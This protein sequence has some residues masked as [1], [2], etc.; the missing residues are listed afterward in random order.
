MVLDFTAKNLAFTLLVDL[1]SP[2]NKP[3]KRSRK[4]GEYRPGDL[5]FLHVELDDLRTIKASADEFKAQEMKLHV[6][7]YRALP[8][9]DSQSSE[10]Q[11]TVSPFTV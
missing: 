4:Q 1:N 6:L 7:H 3:S 10:P 11:F 2:L 8:V 9:S 5:T